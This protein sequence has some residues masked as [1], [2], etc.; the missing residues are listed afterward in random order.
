MPILRLR[1]SSSDVHLILRPR[2]KT[3][4]AGA[5]IRR[6]HPIIA[7]H[8]CAALTVRVR[9]S[10]AVVARHAGRFAAED[11]APIVELKHAFPGHQVCHSPRQKSCLRRDFIRR[12]QT[13]L[14]SSGHR[15][16]HRRDRLGRRSGIRRRRKRSRRTIPRRWNGCTIR[17]AGTLYRR[18][19]D[20]RVQ[21]GRI[22]RGSRAVDRGPVRCNG[23]RD[24]AAKR[25]CDG[26]NR[27]HNETTR[28]L[29]HGMTPL[30]KSAGASA[31]H[32]PFAAL[33]APSSN[34]GHCRWLTTSLRMNAS[35]VD[36]SADV[37]P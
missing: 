36:A 1:A 8:V 30:A 19:R 34:P 37:V 29:I 25:R 35:C 14:Q 9:N 20:R 2:R 27:M 11:F 22:D 7:A 13:C 16:A 12:I 33:V 6:R 23:N 17:G 18:N 10:A 31:L 15:R 3:A 28:A 4:R 32:G 26:P 21:G 24:A 5:L